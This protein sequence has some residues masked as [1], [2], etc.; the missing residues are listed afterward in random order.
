MHAAPI[1]PR[2]H[3]SV[4]Q[5]TLR[6]TLVSVGCGLAAAFFLTRFLAKLLFDVPQTDWQLSL[7]CRCAWEESCC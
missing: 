6:L 3:L 2:I 4:W 5:P 7:A 1:V